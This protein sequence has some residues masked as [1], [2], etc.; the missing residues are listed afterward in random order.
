MPSVILPERF[1]SGDF[2]SWLRHFQRCSLANEWDQDM[3]LIKLPAFLQGAAATYF[4]ALVDE[5][6]T[7]L[8]GL[9]ASLAKCFTPPTSRERYHREFEEQHLR[10][11]DDQ[12]LFLW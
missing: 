8:D 3:Q 10:P 5:D 4:D 12:A 2:S 11:S 6:K 9:I 1:S 7:T